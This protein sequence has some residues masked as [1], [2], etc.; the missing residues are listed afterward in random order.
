MKKQRTLKYIF[1]M[2]IGSTLLVGGYESAG[3]EVP[4]DKTKSES[5]CEVPKRTATQF[6]LSAVSS[7]TTDDFYR[8]NMDDRQFL[9]FGDTDH[10]DSRIHDYFYSKEHI[11]RLSSL[12]VKHI[13]IERAPSQSQKGIDDLVTGKITPEEFAT[14]YAGGGMWDRDG[15]KEARIR[16]AEGMVYATGRG[17]KIHASD[18]KSKGIATKEER[19]ELYKYFGDMSSEFNRL[20]PGAESMTDEFYD[21]YVEK[22]ADYLKKWGTRF[23][24]I[25][26]E[27]FNDTNRVNYI[28]SIAGNERSAIIYGAAH[29]SG[30]QSIK[31]LLGHDNTVHI[32]LF[33]DKRKSA[34]YGPSIKNSDFAQVID[35]KRIYKIGTLDFKTTPDKTQ[36][37]NTGGFKP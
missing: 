17:M 20:C 22:R 13:F 29:F 33:P 26:Q 32:N 28:K 25:M 9:L 31:I 37:K 35:Q 10:S 24:E 4:L 21:Y 34:E 36:K 6:D 5:F 8:S 1:A 30:P 15:A 11:D 16:V 7:Q 14:K 3:A 27:R 19:E 23:N 18:I 12:G 2:A